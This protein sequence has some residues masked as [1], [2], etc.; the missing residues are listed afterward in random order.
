MIWFL[1]YAIVILIG[2]KNL[3]YEWVDAYFA[4][5]ALKNVTRDTFVRWFDLMGLQRHLKALLTFSRK[6]HRDGQINYLQHIPR[7]L[8]ISNC[9]CTL[10]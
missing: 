2:R 4:I 3:F 10:S 8:I 5:A 6:Y 7:T 9:E 1:Y